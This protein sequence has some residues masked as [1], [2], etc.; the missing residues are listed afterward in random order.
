MTH[1]VPFAITKGFPAPDAL[2][3]PAMT[4]RTILWLSALAAAFGGC[5]SDDGAGAKTTSSGLSAESCHRQ[6]DAKAAVTG[7]TPDVDLSFCKALCDSTAKDTPA[8][9]AGKFTGYY[10]CSAQAGFECAGSSVQ[11]KGD[12]CHA[13]LTAFAD[14]QNGGKAPVCQGANDAGACPSVECPCASGTVPVSGISYVSGSCKCLD[15]T[16]CLDSC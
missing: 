11:Q 6:C 5:S 9:C 7:C 12:A 2:L 1:L 15:T 10:D 8:E 3:C 13:D 4:L 16:T 14:C